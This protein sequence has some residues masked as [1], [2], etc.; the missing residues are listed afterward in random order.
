MSINCRF[1][2]AVVEGSAKI[3]PGC[4]KVMPSFRGSEIKN[5]TSL[6]RE[7]ERDGLA[8]VREK[9]QTP[10]SASRSGRQM[11]RLDENYGTPNA[12][13]EHVPDNYDPRTEIKTKYNQPTGSGKQSNR[14]VIGP[15][16]AYI[17]KFIILITA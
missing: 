9:A 1:C 7:N 15:G 12:R 13:K 8:N 5:K 11:D 4:G 14:S 3:C 17:I 6:S 10:Y 16:L 2:G